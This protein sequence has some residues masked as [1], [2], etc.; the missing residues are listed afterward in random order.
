[1]QTKYLKHVYTLGQWL[2]RI[3]GIRPFSKTCL[4]SKQSAGILVFRKMTFPEVLLVHPGGP[5]YVT[6][7][8]GVWSV[9]KGEYETGEDP[10]EVGKREFFEETGNK[11]KSDDFIEL[12]PVKSKGGKML[13]VWASEADFEKSFICSN[14]FELEWPPK[15]G[16]TQL[17][18]ECDKAE[19][20]NFEKAIHKIFPYQKP[21]L[22][23]LET[24]IKRNI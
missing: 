19:W 16:K 8:S 12:E 22:A 13:Y 17:F 14:T 18:P 15:S 10:L 20:F 3:Y 2:Y 9:P 4:M 23:Q 24:I 6:K 11:I 7:D 5:F 1:M 21:L